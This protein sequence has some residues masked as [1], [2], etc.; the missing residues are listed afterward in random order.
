MQ[1]AQYGSNTRFFN[2]VSKKKTTAKAVAD[3]F[4]LADFL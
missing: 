1:G 2:T 3:A 4:A